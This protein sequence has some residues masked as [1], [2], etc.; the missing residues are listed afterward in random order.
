MRVLLL[1]L[2]FIP[3][4]SFGLGA[5]NEEFIGF[6]LEGKK[7]KLEL[8]SD[9]VA[10]NGNNFIYSDKHNI[11]YKYCWPTAKTGE[12]KRTIFTLQCT[13]EEKTKP[14]VVYKNQPDSGSEFYREIEM[15][16]KRW[17]PMDGAI[18]I[19][20]KCVIGCD[21]NVAPLIFSLVHGDEEN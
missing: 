11:N 21:K 15:F 2:L 20:Y 9:P 3:S 16:K 6:D 13:S 17:G 8:F 5:E 12:D 14:S 10:W 18:L 19:Y 1:A 4:L 7:I